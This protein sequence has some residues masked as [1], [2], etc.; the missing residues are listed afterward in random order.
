MVTRAL[1]L[2]LLSISLWLIALYLG[3]SGYFQDDWL[4][5]LMAPVVAA[6]GWLAWPSAHIETRK[7]PWSY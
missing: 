2:M 3:V 1:S 6:G 7:S 4:L 5:F